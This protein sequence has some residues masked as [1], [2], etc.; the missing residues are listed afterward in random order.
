MENVFNRNL[1]KVVFSRKKLKMSHPSLTFNR[2]PVTQ[3]GFLIHLL[4][5]LD[6]KLS[7]DEHLRN[8]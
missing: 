5:S 6:N 1:S 7:F 2:I 3:V 4:T 8:I